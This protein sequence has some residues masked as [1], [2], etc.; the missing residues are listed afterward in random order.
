MATTLVGIGDSDLTTFGSLETE[1]GFE[2]VQHLA[3]LASR[4]P[5]GNAYNELEEALHEAGLP[6]VEVWSKLRHLQLPFRFELEDG[7][8]MPA[9]SFREIWET[10]P[11]V[12]RAVLMP[13]ALPSVIEQSWA[14]IAANYGS[15][16]IARTLWQVGDDFNGRIRFER[17]LDPNTWYTYANDAPRGIT[18]G[19]ALIGLPSISQVNIRPFEDTDLVET[20]D[21]LYRPQ[22]PRSIVSVGAQIADPK[23]ALSI[24]ALSVAIGI[25]AIVAGWLVHE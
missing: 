23:T 14:E 22:A 24:G 16:T 12:Y 19:T 2:R 20:V 1:T 11:G 18:K 25:V 9:S 8:I 21:E 6:I 7:R 4:D 10:E 3:A 5:S 15:D 17:R 13:D